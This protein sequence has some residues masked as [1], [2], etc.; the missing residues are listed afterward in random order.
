MDIHE[1]LSLEYAERHQT[2]RDHL[3]MYAKAVGF[4]LAIVAAA[5]TFILQNSPKT[6]GLVIVIFVFLVSGVGLAVSGTFLNWMKAQRE[7]LDE[8]SRVLE[9]RA[10]NM[11][12]ASTGVWLTIIVVVLIVI[13]YIVLLLLYVVN[14]P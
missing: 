12:T 5:T 11:N 1:R 7:R 6:L 3:S 14:R 8:I 4:Y 13:A 10:E 9:I 2:Y